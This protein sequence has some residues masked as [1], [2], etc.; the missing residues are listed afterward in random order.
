MLPQHSD[1]YNQQ[2]FEEVM[3]IHREME[4]IE[5]SEAPGNVNHTPEA[6]PIDPS[7]ALNMDNSQQRHCHA[8]STEEGRKNDNGSGPPS[9]P[10]G[11]PTLDSSQSTQELLQQAFTPISQPTVRGDHYITPD[12]SKGTPVPN[13]MH[14]G[15]AT[16]T[17][18]VS[19]LL[20]PL[21]PLS[22]LLLP[23]PVLLPNPPHLQQCGIP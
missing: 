11:M 1:S 12:V 17:G 13:P 16:P 6:P 5:Q 20:Q 7:Q 15:G 4:R 23:L 18:R 22:L 2:Q 14:Y 9:T 21:T 19:T 3:Q 8:P 10:P